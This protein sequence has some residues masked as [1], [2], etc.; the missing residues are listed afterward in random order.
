MKYVGKGH[1]A[2]SETGTVGS[3]R[4]AAVSRWTAMDYLFILF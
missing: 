4:Q 3:A 2:D 1:A